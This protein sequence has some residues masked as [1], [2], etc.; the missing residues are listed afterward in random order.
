MSRRLFA[1]GTLRRGHA[2]ALLAEL[3]AE[4]QWEGAASVA[5]RLYDL[6]PYPGAV[7]DA[8][9]ATRIHGELAQVPEDPAF[10]ELLDD[11]EAV[12]SVEPLF[13]RVGAEARRAGGEGVPVWVYEYARPPGAAPLV[14]GGRYRPEAGRGTLG[15]PDRR[16]E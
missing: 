1:Y 6:G 2:P 16:R 12:G 13:R 4:L 7:L 8:R 15:D 9:A 11:Y 3:V 10:W 5:G 14:A